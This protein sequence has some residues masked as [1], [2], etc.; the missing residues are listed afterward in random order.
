MVVNVGVTATCAAVRRRLVRAWWLGRYWVL[1]KHRRA[2]LAVSAATVPA[3]A[4][5][6][7]AHWLYASPAP[8]VDAPALAFGWLGYLVVIAIAAVI[9]LALAPRPQRPEPQEAQR[10]VV[11]DGAGVVR[12]YGDVWVDDP[13]LLGWWQVGMDPIKQGGKK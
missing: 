2:V 1:W 4:G 10:P 13:V 6:G 7:L 12:I 3:A 9:S 8:A 5:F 11:E